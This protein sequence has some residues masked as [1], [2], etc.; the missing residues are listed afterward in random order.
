MDYT[1]F[2]FFLLVFV[3]IVSF[4]GSSTVFSLKGMPNIAKVGLALML[5]FLTVNAIKYDPQLLP[6]SSLSLAAGCA[7]ECFFGLMLGFATSLVFHAMQMAGQYMDLQVGFSMA[8]EYDSMNY[9]NVTLIGNLAKLMGICIFFAI[10]GHHALIRCII[11][12]FEVVPVGRVNPTG[13]VFKYIISM[14]LQIF[15]L[16]VKIAAPVVITIFLTDFTIGLISRT[17]PQLNVLMLGIPVKLLVGLLV[18]GASLPWI[19]HT[20]VIA[21]QQLSK[22]IG[23]FF[24]VFPAV[25]FFAAADEKTEEPTEKKLEDARKKGQAAKSRE[26]VSAVTLFGVIFVVTLFGKSALSEIENFLSGCVDSAGRICVNYR[27]LWNILVGSII[28]FFKIMLPMF[29][30][31]VIF[32]IIANVAQT[33]FLHSSDP[34]KPRAERIN[35]LSGFKR[36]FSLQ[37]L[38]ELLKSIIKISTLVYILVSYVKSQLPRI[39]LSSDRGLNSLMSLPADI[40]KTELVR[41]AIFAGI[42]GAVD[43]YFQRFSYN[44]EMRMTKEEVKEEYKETE[45]NPETKSRIKK[46]QREIANRRMM[47]RVPEAT[48]V[49]TN[50]TH[51][52]VALKYDR[53]KDA[54]PVVVAKGVD[55]IAQRIKRIARDNDVPIIE[56][57]PVARMLYKKVDIEEAIPVEMYQVVAEILAM[58]YSIKRK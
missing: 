34:I 32:G 43:F 30:V 9:T 53:E 16:S 1:E 48:V 33:G 5:A 13:G 12:S 57:K 36:I 58:V 44:R 50:P 18:L 46:K 23:N 27:G 52:A 15:G 3:R 51:I 54:A 11:K 8:S 24:K 20:C 14:I 4:I 25:I 28:E 39:A 6:A 22:N 35:P 37:T 19:V 29:L 42:L 17:V 38:M 55:E 49:I 40:A 45:G 56:N 21:F 26:F 7:G 2:V 41:T 31:V 47:H 10:N